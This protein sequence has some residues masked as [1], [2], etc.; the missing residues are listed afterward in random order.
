[1]NKIRNFFSAAALLVSSLLMGTAQAAP[2]TIGFEGVVG[3]GQASACP[4]GVPYLESGFSLAASPTNIC[5]SYILNNVNGNN[6]FGNTTSVMG[7]CAG[8]Q[9][10]LT[11]TLTAADPFSAQSIDIGS[12]FNSDPSAITFVG[13]FVGG[14][15][16]T[17]VIDGGT[18]WAT[19]ALNGFSNLSSMT[20]STDGGLQHASIDNIVLNSATVPEPASL[21]LV[22]LALAA[23]GAVRRRKAV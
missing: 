2:V 1:M 17:Q 18:R 12:Y 14:G 23:V 10:G 4:S 3:S 19:Y 7:I 6:G 15:S 21:A 11:L 20:I 9:G 8:C 13:F 22:G 16:I 5:N